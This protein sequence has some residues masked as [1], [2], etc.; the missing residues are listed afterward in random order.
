MNERYKEQKN[1]GIVKEEKMSDIKEMMKAMV[2][3]LMEGDDN[4]RHIPENK[5]VLAAFLSLK[6]ADY[7][8]FSIP[9]NVTESL[10]HTTPSPEDKDTMNK[11]R[12]VYIDYIIDNQDALFEVYQN[13][14]NEN[15]TYI[16][17][18]YTSMAMRET[19]LSVAKAVE[20]NFRDR[21][22]DEIHKDDDDMER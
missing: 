20:E 10:L 7:I 4:L 9:D 16:T 21:E 2:I 18:T 19:I 5:T 11:I 15:S 3:M 8:M 6:A 22:A 12:S 17:E 14:L 1:N 13:K